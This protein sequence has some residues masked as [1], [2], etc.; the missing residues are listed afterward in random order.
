MVVRYRRGFKWAAAA[1]ALAAL[2]PAEAAG[3]GD[4]TLAS[5]SGDS[6]RIFWFLHV[7]DIHIGAGVKIN[8]EWRDWRSSPYCVGPSL[9]IEGTKLKVA[10]ATML[11]L[12]LDKWVSFEITALLGKDTWDMTVTLPGEAPKEFRGLQ[13]GHATFDQLTWVGFTSNAT[14]KTVFYID[15]LKLK[16]KA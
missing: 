15:N 9:W 4:P 12:P 11:E 13:N 8:H 5:Y 3:A 1:L 6:D 16:N 10:G 7:T 2:A 14:K